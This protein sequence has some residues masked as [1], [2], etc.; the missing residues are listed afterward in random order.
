MGSFKPYLLSHFFRYR[1]KGDIKYGPTIITKE[2]KK[3]K[4]YLSSL[5]DDHSRLSVQ[6]ELYDN[7]RAEVVEDTFHKAVLKVGTWDCSYLD[8]TDVL[9]IP[10]F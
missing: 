3:V 9:T 10:K 6:S 2:G 1:D 7:Q 5:I 4:T 8:Y